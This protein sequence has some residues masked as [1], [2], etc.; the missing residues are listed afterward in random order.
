M[1]ADVCMFYLAPERIFHPV[2]RRV[3]YVLYLAIQPYLL[4]RS[5]AQSSVSWF[6]H[7]TSW[8][9]WRRGG[10]RLVWSTRRV[11]LSWRDGG[12][13]GGMH[14]LV[15]GEGGGAGGEYWVF[16]YC[17]NWEVRR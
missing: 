13:I 11:T 3:R 14:I 6:V 16:V 17:T 10:T 2:V 5:R 1:R 9:Y 4:R 7:S 8:W 15:V 12:A